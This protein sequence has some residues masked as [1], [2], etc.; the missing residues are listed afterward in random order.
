[1]IHLK[2]GKKFNAKLSDCGLD[3]YFPKSGQITTNNNKYLISA[4]E[5]VLGRKIT[6]F[7]RMCHNKGT[8]ALASDIYS[9][10]VV[11]V[12]L[13]KGEVFKFVETPK[14]LESIHEIQSS[15]NSFYIDFSWKNSKNSVRNLFAKKED[16][17]LM[18]LLKG[19]LERKPEN[20]FDILN[21]KNHP[22]IQTKQN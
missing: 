1:M 18:H 20:R 19:M 14:Q 12:L 8:D 2:Q 13:I 10:G 4:P 5:Y 6:R 17:H 7:Q 22:W 3:L 9:L 15:V 16:K 21:V 11:L